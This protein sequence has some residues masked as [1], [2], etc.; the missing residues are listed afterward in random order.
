[1]ALVNVVN[2]TVFFNCAN[3]VNDEEMLLI[4]SNL[5]IYRK[6]LLEVHFFN[7]GYHDMFH[8]CLCHC[9]MTTASNLM[10]MFYVS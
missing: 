9:I 7:N 3:Q 6:I 1:M 10:L 2:I 4:M 8:R 5:N